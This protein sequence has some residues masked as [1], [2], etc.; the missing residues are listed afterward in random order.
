M[1]NINNMNNYN[2]KINQTQMDMKDLPLVM[3]NAHNTQIN[4]PC[5]KLNFNMICCPQIPPVNQQVQ[6]QSFDKTNN[7]SNFLPEINHKDNS[8]SVNQEKKN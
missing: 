6:K 5:Q 3:N 4:Y 1:N 2:K 8:K 7:S